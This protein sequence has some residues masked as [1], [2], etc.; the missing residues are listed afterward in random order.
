MAYPRI[1][2]NRSVTLKVPDFSGGIDVSKPP[3]DIQDNQATAINNMWLKDG[4]LQ[5]RPAL[6]A[7]SNEAYL[8]SDSS[9]SDLGVDLKYGYNLY[10]SAGASLSDTTQISGRLFRCDKEF[11][12]YDNDKQGFV[13]LLTIFNDN[14]VETSFINGNI[15]NEHFFENGTITLPLETGEN[16][17]YYEVVHSKIYGYITTRTNNDTKEDRMFLCVVFQLIDNE[18]TAQ[19]K[20]YNLT[21]DLPIDYT[22]Y[23]PTVIVGSGASAVTMDDFNL[24]T[25]KFKQQMSVSKD[26]SQY[27]KYEGNEAADSYYSEDVY[28]TMSLGLGDH[29]RD[30]GNDYCCK[31]IKFKYQD[32]PQSTIDRIVVYGTFKFGYWEAPHLEG[33]YQ[34]G[35]IK[36][37]TP[38]IIGG[39]TGT[40]YDVYG[41]TDKEIEAGYYLKS[42][43]VFHESVTATKLIIENPFFDPL[44]RTYTYYDK[45]GREVNPIAKFKA[46]EDNVCIYPSINGGTNAHFSFGIL[47][48]SFPTNARSVKTYKQQIVN[49]YDTGEPEECYE[50]INISDYPAASIFIDEIQIFQSTQTEASRIDL[51]I[52]NPLKTTYGGTNSGYNSGTRLFVAGNPDHKNVLRWSAVN[53][54]SYFLENNFTYIG[55]DDEEITALGKQDGYLVVF[56]E[57][58]L[59]ALE[60]SSTSDS[61]NELIV[62]FPVTPISPYIGCDCPNTIQFVAN[63]L[64]WLTSEGKVYTL[65]S[66]NSYSERNVREISKH[67]ENELK[68]HT[69]EDLK[70]AKS[71]DYNGNYMLFVGKT[72]Y[73]WNYDINPLYNY[74]SSERAQQNL[75]WF[76]WEFPYPVH[77]VCNNNGELAVICNDGTDY[78]GYVLD[79]TKDEDDTVGADG[80]TEITSTY[81]SKTWD[82]GSPFTF[83]RIN[84]AFFE[85]QTMHD[86]DVKVYFVTESGKEDVPATLD[87]QY[88][89]EENT[90]Y[91]TRPHLTRVRS[92]GFELESK[93][94]V[95]LY[96]AAVTAEIYGEVK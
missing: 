91:T 70:A 63:R 61:N 54:F 21:D 39:G 4:A 76:K 50:L 19:V 93:V 34:Y 32:V 57:K 38:S 2:N 53:D 30:F 78:Q 35:Y 22:P 45:N 95:K 27:K 28:T 7:G 26:L 89:T 94:A 69:P 86:G 88:T 40:P 71:V 13:S 72:V 59:Y 1:G 41:K 52:K 23:S 44:Q 31:N 12:F 60:Y 75:C 42:D 5:T 17:T 47:T 14:N 58:E 48:I 10:S 65:Y 67:I 9:L 64:T 90:T 79:Y 83:K 62:Y 74:S 8:P 82:Y 11:Y 68:K 77:Y 15:E 92:M 25:D 43:P 18:I 96:S 20:I 81:R 85:V 49:N 51:V 80:T 66:E 6:S 33:K 3:Q 73:I 16:G 24:M 55:R 87:A 56:K 84:R 36:T 29:T 37:V 46:D